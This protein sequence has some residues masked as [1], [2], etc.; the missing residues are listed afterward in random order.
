MK[1][2]DQPRQV[3][4]DF[5]FTENFAVARREQARAVNDALQAFVQRV[6]R[7]FHA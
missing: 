5:D 4:A 1:E 3:P 7:F 2:Q 6:G